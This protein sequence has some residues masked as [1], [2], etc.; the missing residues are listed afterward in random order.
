[1]P[2][3]AAIAASTTRIRIATA[4]VP[5]PLH[6][7]LRLAEDAA[8]LDVVS[9]GRFELGV[10]LGVDAS[11][12]SGF[13]LDSAERT[14]RFEEAVELLRLA[15]RGEPFA[16][17]GRHFRFATLEVSPRP[18][19]EG[20]PPLWVGAS[21]EAAQRRAARLGAGLVVPAACACDAY[22]AACD[23]AGVTPRVALLAEEAGEARASLAVLAGAGVTPD[24]WLDRAAGDSLA[25]LTTC[26]DRARAALARG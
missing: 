19:Q 13:G 4:L 2:V 11:E 16:F 18:L 9:G 22:L 8:T 5:L 17:D 20:G 6:H 24:L 10:G 7:P 1:V 23:S 26:R 12:L 15:W 25:A 14:S 21:A 3:C